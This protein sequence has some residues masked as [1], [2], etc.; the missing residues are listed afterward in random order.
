MTEA[1]WIADEFYPLVYHHTEGWF[2]V[3]PDASLEGYYA[4][5]FTTQSWIWS[6]DNLRGWRFNFDTRNWETWEVQ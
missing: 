1:G 4:Y 6:A 2:R 5:D 3:H